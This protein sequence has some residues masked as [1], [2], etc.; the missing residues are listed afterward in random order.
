MCWVQPARCQVAQIQRAAHRLHNSRM[1]FHGVEELHAQAEANRTQEEDSCQAEGNCP[2]EDS[3]DTA[4][5]M[6]HSQAVDCTADKLQVE[7]RCRPPEVRGAWLATS[8]DTQAVELHMDHSVD[9]TEEH[10]NREAAR[11]AHACW[12]RCFYF[13]Y[14]SVSDCSGRFEPR[15]QE[16]LGAPPHGAQNGIQHHVCIDRFLQTYTS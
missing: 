3:Q 11:R 13:C 5:C 9:T 10:H 1:D 4:P 8:E 2:A 15:Q 12:T 14:D 16:G 6:G 7:E